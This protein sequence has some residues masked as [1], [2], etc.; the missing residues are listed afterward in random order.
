MGCSMTQGIYKITNTKTGESYIGKS[1]NIEQRIKQ[2]KN[3]LRKGTHHNSDLQSD[4]SSGAG[5]TFEI[6]K[7]VINAN[8]LD[9]EE[10]AE[11]ARYDT[12][13]HGYNQSPG[14]QYDGYG[15]NVGSGRLNSE[16]NFNSKHYSNYK[17]KICPKCGRKILKN[18][19]VC[20]C[21]YDFILEMVPKIKTRSRKELQKEIDD[22]FRKL[23]IN[24]IKSG[25]MQ[26]KLRKV[27][28]AESKKPNVRKSKP[29]SDYPDK[30]QK[31]I[32]AEFEVIRSERKKSNKNLRKKYRATL[33]KDSGAGFGRSDVKKSN[34]GI[35][36]RDKLQKEIDAEFEKLDI[37]K[38]NS[39]INRHNPQKESGG[40]FE[41][42]NVSNLIHKL[43]STI[44][45]KRK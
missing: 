16:S 3:E 27:S 13:H 15:R 33:P 30:L 36:H 6:I 21:G 43:I 8:E 24:R 40:G 12:F 31:E 41:K 19:S 29:R 9:A 2:H 17:N 1:V 39:T 45:S 10:R 35:N 44:S 11:I 5:F 22:E 23:D 14:G 18:S 25:S 20:D 37:K 26:R 7:R 38:S 4:Y 34:S 42:F 32:D 28:S